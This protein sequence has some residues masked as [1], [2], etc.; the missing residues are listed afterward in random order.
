MLT[1]I[2]QNSTSGLPMVGTKNRITALAI[3][4]IPYRRSALIHLSAMMPAIEG[5]NSAAMPIVEKIAPKL[6]PDQCLFW[7]HH[8]PIVSSHAPQMK[9]WRNTITI[10]RSFRFIGAPRGAPLPAGARASVGSTVSPAS[11]KWCNDVVTVETQATDG[12]QQS[13]N[14]RRSRCRA[15][16]PIARARRACPSTGT[17]EFAPARDRQEAQGSRADWMSARPSRPAPSF[18]RPFLGNAKK[19]PARNGGARK[20][21]GRRKYVSRKSTQENP[22]PQRREQRGGTDARRAQRQP[23]GEARA[24]EHHR[25]VG[26]QHA[27]GAAGDHLPQ[28]LIARAQH[29]GGDLGAVAQFGQEECDDGR[30]ENAAPCMGGCRRI[31]AALVRE[32]RPHRDREKR[33]ADQPAL[34]VRR[35]PMRQPR[36]GFRRDR[37][38]DQRRDQ[39]AGADRPRLA[40]FRGQHQRQQLRLVADLGQRDRAECDQ[41]GL[42][43]KLRWAG[44]DDNPRAMS[45]PRAHHART[46]G[47]AAS[48]AMSRAMACRP[49]VLTRIPRRRAEGGYSPTERAQCS[50][51]PSPAGTLLQ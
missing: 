14:R 10:R 40:E 48:Q 13:T 45:R 51:L 2:T 30:D 36:A 19:G 39:D 41:E 50:K 44:N 42:Q 37:V 33:Q 34:H 32:Q 38:A 28:R 21:H 20:R 23:R 7:N 16:Q 27:G 11:F 46:A 12:R 49:S 29:R 9:Y 35:Q 26:D 47:L 1:S 6:V 18:F 43:G 22:Q 8:A 31:V 15:S 3:W 17:C 25:H 4:K 24:Q 5:M